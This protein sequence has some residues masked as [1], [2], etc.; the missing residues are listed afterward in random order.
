MF[1]TLHSQKLDKFQFLPK[2]QK[3]KKKKVVDSFSRERTW[4]L[5][6]K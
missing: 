1:T 6:P 5:I 2:I 4:T 3:T